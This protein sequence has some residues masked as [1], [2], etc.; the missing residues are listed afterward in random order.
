MKIS[1]SSMGEALKRHRRLCT[2]VL[3]VIAL[4]GGV[5]LGV[6]L[7]RNVGI[8]L[9]DRMAR[10]IGTT[11]VTV[12][13]CVK[14]GSALTL[15]LEFPNVSPAKEPKPTPGEV[16]KGFSPQHDWAMMNYSI[17]LEAVH[18][19]MTDG[20]FSAGIDRVT[21][22]CQHGG[23]TM[24]TITG[25]RVPKNEGVSVDKSGKLIQA[26]PFSIFDVNGTDG[27]EGSIGMLFPTE[28]SKPAG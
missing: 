16:K 3:T 12:E 15:T 6:V 14:S 26:P 1:F 28:S 24:A 5:A 17:A 4:L 11:A 22:V 20:P 8:S 23:K 13:S 19:E 25:D 2:V 7:E 27:S 10:R 9:S 18:E 21:V